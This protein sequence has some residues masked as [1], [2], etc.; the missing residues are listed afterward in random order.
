MR[1][2]PTA[3]GVV[4]ALW[5]AAVEPAAALRPLAGRKRNK[6]PYANWKANQKIPK[7]NAARGV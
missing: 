1:F 6:T 3:N 7:P 4:G 2:S 5:E